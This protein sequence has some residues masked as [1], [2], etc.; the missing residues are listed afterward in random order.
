MGR[1]RSEINSGD[2]YNKRDKNYIA[3]ITVN[4]KPIYL[5]AFKTAEEAAKAYDQYVIENK[6]NKQL[7]WSK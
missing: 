3:K 7:N 4:C 5:G 1:R 6:L 2:S